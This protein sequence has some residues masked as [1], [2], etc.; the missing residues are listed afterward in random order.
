LVLIT[1]GE[2]HDSFPVEAAE[3]AGQR[4]V[5]IIAI[6]LGDENQGR[7]IPITDESGNRTFLKY[8]GQEVWSKL[9][10]ATLRKMANATPGGRYLN[11]STGTID[12]GDV[13]V[14]L[15]A[16]E[17]KREIE[18]LTIKLYEEK[19][20]IF[21]AIALA[22][23]LAEMIVSERRRKKPVE[24]AAAAGGA[25][26]ASMIVVLASAL[27]LSAAPSADAESPEGLVKKGNSDFMAGEYEKALELYERASVK[28][29]E[30]AVIA[31]NLG[32]VYYRMDDFAKAREKFQEAAMKTRELPLEARAWYNIGNC[33]F[34]EGARQLDSDLEKALGLYRESVG[35][36]Q[37]ALEKD[38][39]LSD[40]A[41]NME[42]ARL[43]IKDLLDRIQKQKEEMDKMREKL[44]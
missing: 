26:K 10:A 18:S 37:T 31:F 19:Y 39:E 44:K 33:A 32:D 12:L 25:V 7:R 16:G 23:L 42:I 36:Y 13:Y 14:K 35:F 4:G 15:I 30:S 8:E 2:D 21:L 6:G 38:P 24:R 1:D 40:A 22:L 17:E 20:Q 9:D 43:M 29:P 28:S 5:R 34:S 3:E 11:V 27:L 41:H